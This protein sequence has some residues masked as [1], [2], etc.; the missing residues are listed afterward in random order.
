MTGLDA[1]E[2]GTQE[3]MLAWQEYQGRVV[4]GQKEIEESAVM[5]DAEAQK[6]ARRD[7]SAEK[8]AEAESNRALTDAKFAQFIGGGETAVDG[9]RE[10]TRGENAFASFINSPEQTSVVSNV[11]NVEENVRNAE[12]NV[13][14]NVVSNVKN[15]EDNVVRNVKESKE[16]VENEVHNVVTSGNGIEPLTTESTTVSSPLDTDVEHKR[17]VEESLG[18]IAKNTEA[19]VVG[20]KSRAANL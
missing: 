1:L 8:I 6:Q 10:L 18:I 7:R 12:D 2:A 17:T 9:G 16:F 4:S 20:G 15:V 3:A 14:S 11:K 5:V 13:T 19:M